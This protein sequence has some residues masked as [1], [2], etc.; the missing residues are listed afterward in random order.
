MYYDRLNQSQ[1]KNEKTSKEESSLL[2]NPIF[3]ETEMTKRE[4]YL[5]GRETGNSI[6]EHNFQDFINQTD[7]VIDFILTNLYQDDEPVHQFQCLVSQIESEHYRQFSPFEF[8]AQDFNE[9]H[10]PDGMWS[11][12]ERGVWNG[13]K[14][15]FHKLNQETE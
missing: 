9:S 10:D 14:Q 12:Y 6:A 8:T 7:E 5:I 4:A 15:T 3:Q 13:S 2:T 1:T 11:E